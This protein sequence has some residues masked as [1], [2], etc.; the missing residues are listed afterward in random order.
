MRTIGTFAGAALLALATPSVAHADDRIS[1]RDTA[2]EEA[3][4][5][6]FAAE[7]LTDEQ[8]ARVPA[9]MLVVDK[10]F[11]DGAYGRMIGDAVKPMMSSLLG[12]SSALPFVMVAELIGVPAAEVEDMGE[13]TVAQVMAIVDPAWEE[14]TVVTTDLTLELLE[15][16]V[17]QV[18]PPMRAGLARAYAV[19]FTNAQLAELSAFFETETG[20]Y[21]AGESFI[22]FADPQVMS[23]MQA[24][25]PAM[26]NIVPELTKKME[27]RMAALPPV[28]RYSELNES[29]RRELAGLF[30]MTL[31]ELE[32]SRG[33]F[34]GSV[35]PD[36]PT[37]YEEDTSDETAETT[38]EE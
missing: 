34:L 25:M 8:E 12:S 13:T 38:S 4:A 15:G 11:P 3:M 1:D 17:A 26:M 21:Y 2:F 14:R 10:I 20:G 5:K 29:E 19:R 33:T 37:T 35:Y 28:R 24:M 36:G 32:E 23:A 31:E 7:P 27:E 16:I 18:E 22:I 6:A 9:A 30:G